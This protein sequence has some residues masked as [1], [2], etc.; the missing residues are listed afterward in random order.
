MNVMNLRRFG[1][2]RRG[3]QQTR[4]WLVGVIVRAASRNPERSAAESK[5]PFIQCR[6]RYA[7]AGLAERHERCAKAF[8]VAA[9]ANCQIAFCAFAVAFETS[10]MKLETAP[11]GD[12]PKKS[13]GLTSG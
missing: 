9:H 10:N 13:W 12:I 5:E 1:G 4:F 8:H 3:P 6:K 11:S 2:V 7:T